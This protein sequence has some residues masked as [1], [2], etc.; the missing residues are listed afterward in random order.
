MKKCK[1]CGKECKNLG[2]HIRY[3]H[4]D[5]SAKDY[6]DKY[7]DSNKIYICQNPKCSNETKFHSL[8]RG[9]LKTCSEKCHYQLLN[10][11]GNVYKQTTIDS[12]TGF[13]LSKKIA[14]KRRAIQ[15]EQQ[16]KINPKTG[17]TYLSEVAK[18]AYSNMSNESEGFWIIKIF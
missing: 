17:K 2:Q 3:S 5:I 14:I 16:R 1:L 6:Y 18:R 7:V 15:L 11:M 13:T 8:W 9:Y 12:E 10:Y 4:S